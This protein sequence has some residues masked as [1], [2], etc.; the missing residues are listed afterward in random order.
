LKSSVIEK[1]ILI[2][3][4]KA[5]LSVA[6]LTELSFGFALQKIAIPESLNI[7]ITDQAVRTVESRARFSFNNLA[8]PAIVP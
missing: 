6:K 4:N 1:N 8:G 2:N 7:I 3:F 5:P